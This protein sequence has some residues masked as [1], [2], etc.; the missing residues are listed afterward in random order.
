MRQRLLE[1]LRCPQCLGD[2][3]LEVF[4]TNGPHVMEGVLRCACAAWY[5][6]IKGVPR[7][8][9]G[10]LRGDYSGL[11]ERLGLDAG[12]GGVTSPRSSDAAVTH[13]ARLKRATAGSFGFEWTAYNRFGWTE[14]DLGGEVE[15]IDVADYQEV[16][17]EEQFAH[18]IPTFRRKTLLAEEDLRNRLVLD[19]GCGNGRYAFVARRFGAEVVGIDLSDVVDAAFSNTYNLE[20]VH[21]VQSDAF[22]PPFPHGL[23]DIIYSIGVLHHT[24]SAE[25]ATKGL[26]SL[27]KPDGILSVHLYRRRNPVYEGVDRFLRAVSTRLPLSLCWS[28]CYLPTA[29]GKLLF[30]VRP[31]FAG[32]NALVS[33]YASHHHNF[34]W[35]SAPIAT[36]H[37]EEEVAYWLYDAG[38]EA[39]VDDSPLVHGESY[40]AR[41]YPRWARHAD[42][43]VRKW[44]HV[45]CPHWALTVRG[46]RPD[47]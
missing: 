19:V 40:Y 30:P 6:I 44:V 47:V 17:R 45:L 15:E 42:G 1:I 22:R 20:G 12:E 32:V 10:E 25:S 38:L 36:H 29:I 7:M 31:L 39:V 18:T 16:Y 13:G 46:K 3:C 4:E 24:P 34:D 5:P 14:E 9:L 37:T 23:F 26:V 27:L 11:A 21:I 35:Y 41:I 28:L 33:V 43:T 2:L 8:L